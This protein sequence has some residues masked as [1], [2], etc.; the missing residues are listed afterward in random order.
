M[1]ATVHDIGAFKGLRDFK[2]GLLLLGW[3]LRRVRAV[4]VMRDGLGSGSTG[5]EFVSM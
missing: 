1:G 4:G 5:W 2:K 3:D